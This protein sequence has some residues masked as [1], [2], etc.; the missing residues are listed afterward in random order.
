VKKRKETENEEK[1]QRGEKEGIRLRK[2]ERGTVMKDE[3]KAWQKGKIIFK[4][5][6]FLVLDY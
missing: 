6:T 5:K 2:K 3:G 1:R 4:I